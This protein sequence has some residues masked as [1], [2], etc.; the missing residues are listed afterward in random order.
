MLVVVYIRPIRVELDDLSIVYH[1]LL[2]MKDIDGGNNVDHFSARNEAVV[3]DVVEVEGPVE[4]LIDRALRGDRNGANEFLERDHA[5]LES[6]V[7]HTWH[8]SR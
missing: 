4:L 6:C 1:R 3:V 7:N 8:E 2:T 5:I